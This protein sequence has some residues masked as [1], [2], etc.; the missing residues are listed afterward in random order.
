MKIRNTVARVDRGTPHVP[1][2]DYLGRAGLLAEFTLLDES[3]RSHGGEFV[4]DGMLAR[5]Q[6]TVAAF[7]LHLATMDIRE[8][9]DAH[10]QVIGQLMAT[11]TSDGEPDYAALSSWERLQRLAAELGR[12]VRCVLARC[13]WT[14]RGSGRSP[15]S[16]R[17]ARRWTPMARRWLRATSCR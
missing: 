15:C 3:L 2:R 8:H 17:S 13:A 16:R 12:G 10:H 9:A 14:R 6:R 4:A 1:G 7:G 5:V 11:V